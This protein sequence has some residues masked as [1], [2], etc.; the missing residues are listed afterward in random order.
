MHCAVHSPPVLLLMVGKRMRWMGLF[1]CFF[2]KEV[3]VWKIVPHLLP[4]TTVQNNKEKALKVRNLWE[5]YIIHVFPFSLQ[6][7]ILPIH[8]LINSFNNTFSLFELETKT[9][10]FKQC[11]PYIVSFQKII[12][13]KKLFTKKTAISNHF[14]SL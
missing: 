1:F 13:A 6:Q 11:W 5:T 9:T 14:V 3:I 2:L 10:F 4:V 12:F 8:H 7:E